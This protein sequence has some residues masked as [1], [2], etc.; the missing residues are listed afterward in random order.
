[1]IEL[2]RDVT[3]DEDQDEDEDENGNVKNG[4]SK[5]KEIKTEPKLP[6][7]FV[8]DLLLNN[9]GSPDESVSTQ[10]IPQISTR[11]PRRMQTRSTGSKTVHNP[12]EKKTLS[13]SA[14]EILTNPE[15][16]SLLQMFQHAGGGGGGEGRR[17]GRYFV[18]DRSESTSG[19][20]RLQRD[21]CQPER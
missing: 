5:Q 2:A 10:R 15:L 17:N 21:I 19:S 20:K 9:E 8:A 13:E 7:K 18:A 16:L 12:V 4:K 14:V 3:D 6:E 11:Q 1:M